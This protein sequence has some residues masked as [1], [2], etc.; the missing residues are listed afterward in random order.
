MVIDFGLK[1]IFF[2]L[3]LTVS[4]VMT[5]QHLDVTGKKLSYPLLFLPQ[6][7]VVL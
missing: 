2:T 7:L 1:I 6:N 3:P 4:I 5:A